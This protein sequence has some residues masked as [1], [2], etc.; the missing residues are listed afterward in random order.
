M[1]ASPWLR[2]RG[3]AGGADCQSFTA[4]RSMAEKVNARQLVWHSENLFR[5]IEASL[6]SHPFPC[7]RGFGVVGRTMMAIERSEFFI[8]Y[9]WPLRSHLAEPFHPAF[10]I[11]TFQTG[12]SLAYG[13]IR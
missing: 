12:R 4:A 6:A 3:N 2:F 13:E 9:C 5:L 8:G 1:V 10:A 11:L 7:R